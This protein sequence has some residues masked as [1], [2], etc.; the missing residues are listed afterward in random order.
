[1]KVSEGWRAS[2]LEPEVEFRRQGAFFQI[3]F[4]GHISGAKVGMCMEK[5]LPQCV[6]WSMDAH[7][8]YPRWRMVAILN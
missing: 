2:T 3:S 7:L 5:G 1:M 4:W 8:E 6:E